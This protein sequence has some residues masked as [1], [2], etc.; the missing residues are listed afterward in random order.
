MKSR[1]SEPCSEGPASGPY[2]EPDARANLYQYK[3]KHFNTYVCIWIKVCTI[4]LTL[5]PNA[6]LC[7]MYFH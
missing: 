2:P 6:L 1:G 7:V 3:F 5:S 4:Y